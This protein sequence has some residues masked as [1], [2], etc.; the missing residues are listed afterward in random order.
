MFKLQGDPGAGSV[1][2]GAAKIQGTRGNEQAARERKSICD[3]TARKD[4]R[5]GK[6]KERSGEKHKIITTTPVHCVSQLLLIG[7]IKQH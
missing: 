5:T 7:D 1:R 3:E 6:A 4:E 2:I